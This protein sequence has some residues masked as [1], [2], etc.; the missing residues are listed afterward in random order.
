MRAELNAVKDFLE[1]ADNIRSVLGARS[2]AAADRA[3]IREKRL[4]DTAEIVAIEIERR[5]ERKAGELVRRGQEAG[6][7]TSSSHHGPRQA[8][9]QSITEA[10]PVAKGF[11]SKCYCLASIPAD[12]FDEA[13][14]TAKSEGSLSLRNLV[15]LIQDMDTTGKTTRPRQPANGRQTRRSADQGL[16]SGA[17][18]R[19]RVPVDP[20]A[21]VRTAVA[22]ITDACSYAEPCAGQVSAPVAA[23]YAKALRK[24]RTS[25]SHIID[26][27]EKET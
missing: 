14:K 22:M 7:I 8:L 1:G 17:S 25:L 10:F 13:I 20:D 21:V 2:V 11:R 18:Q 19:S 16:S 23:E 6:E 24:S 12:V 15:R 26:A 9:R 4:G 3:V 5:C 27:L